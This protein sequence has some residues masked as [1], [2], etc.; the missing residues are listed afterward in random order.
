MVRPGRTQPNPNG[1]KKDLSIL[2]L[3]E[4]HIDQYYYSLNIFS[5]LKRMEVINEI[6]KLFVFGKKILSQSCRQKLSSER[7]AWRCKATNSNIT[8]VR[9]C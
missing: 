8:K 9:E 6:I 4:T 2:L 5:L 7:W 1:S 3:P